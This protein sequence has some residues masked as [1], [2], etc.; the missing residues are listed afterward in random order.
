MRGGP[1]WKVEGL[2]VLRVVR[3][4][5]RPLAPVFGDALPRA[6]RADIVENAPFRFKW[7]TSSPSM[8]GAD[9]AESLRS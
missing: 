1:I 9:A 5:V 8:W 7:G 4:D 3:E 6:R 2:V